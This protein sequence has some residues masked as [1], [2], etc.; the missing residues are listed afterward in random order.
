MSFYGCIFWFCFDILLPNESSDWELSFKHT[1]QVGHIQ[2][3]G[4]SPSKTSNSRLNSKMELLI[5]KMCIKLPIHT[6]KWQKKVLS[7]EDIDKTKDDYSLGLHLVNEHYSVERG[8]FNR[9]FKV[10]IMENC[11]P[12]NLEKKEHLLIHKFKTLYP[13][14]LNKNNPFGLSV[15]S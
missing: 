14:G 7:N 3:R 5:K 12:S 10:Q 6:N 8:D 13:I 4:N 1:L 9:Y 2:F 11:S 15:I